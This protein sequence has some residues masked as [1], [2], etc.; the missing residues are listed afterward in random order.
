MNTSGACRSMLGDT[1]QILSRHNHRLYRQGRLYN[2][3][4][5]CDK[6]FTG[7]ATVFA[8]RDDWMVHGA[9]KK[10]F[11]AFMNN[12]KEE[13]A[14]LAKNG[15]KARWQDFRVLTGWSGPSGDTPRDLR[16][17]MTTY[18]GDQ[19]PLL[20]GE[21]TLSEVRTEAA[22]L[23]QFTW[24]GGT[25]TKFNIM[26]EYSKRGNTNSDPTTPVTT[27]AYSDLDDDTQNAQLS[28]LS[29]DGN[30]PPYQANGMEETSVWNKVA[31]LGGGPEAT[32]LSTGYFNAPCGFFVILLDAASNAEAVNDHFFLEV[33]SGTYKGVHSES[34][35]EAKLVKNH[36]QVK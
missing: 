4:I 12:S 20:G 21:F 19:T 8:L 15:G 9:W 1:G 29:S 7:T 16:G 2:I 32:Q 22:G 26:E 11:E 10:A 23:R 27:A 31:T 25:G 33:K 28:H 14:L 18:V 13:M 24:G 30:L 3:R 34:M 17:L 6:T 35:G 5:G 36:Y